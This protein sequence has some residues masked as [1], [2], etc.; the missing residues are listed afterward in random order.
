MGEVVALR[1]GEDKWFIPALL[2]KVLLQLHAQMPHLGAHDVVVAGIEARASSE[3]KGPDLLF[4]D[5]CRALRQTANRYVEKKVPQLRSSVESFT[6]DDSLHQ[7]QT[8]VLRWLRLDL[9]S[10]WNCQ[11]N[12]NPSLGLYVT[13]QDYTT[14]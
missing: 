12:C 11:Q 9:P 4:T 5:G 13:G 3:N 2:L 8:L 1:D 10:V 6:A 7:G 14:P